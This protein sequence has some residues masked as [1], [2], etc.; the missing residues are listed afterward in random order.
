MKITIF[1]DDSVEC[2]DE[3][4]HISEEH[5]ASILMVEELYQANS[6]LPLW[7]TLWL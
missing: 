6:F 3:F 1:W 7:L 4:T 2:S 5:T